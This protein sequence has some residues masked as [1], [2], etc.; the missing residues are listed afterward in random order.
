MATV[1]EAVEA[2]TKEI[3]SESELLEIGGVTTSPKMT[4]GIVYYKRPRDFSDDGFEY[5]IHTFF[6]RDGD[7]V[8]TFEVGDY[9]FDKE[10][11]DAKFKLRSERGY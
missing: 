11:A 7:E 4:Q 10:T 1:Y 5:I 8:A 9:I 3:H 2:R 6:V